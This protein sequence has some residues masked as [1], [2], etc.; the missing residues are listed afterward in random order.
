MICG[1]CAADTQN[2]ESHT[3][4]CFAFRRMNE[5]REAKA[6]PYSA[7]LAFINA[8]LSFAKQENQNMSQ[9]EYDTLRAIGLECEAADGDFHWD[10]P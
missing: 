10:V 2:G 9:A 8:A 6:D 5:M 4:Q 1:Y 7:T 3:V